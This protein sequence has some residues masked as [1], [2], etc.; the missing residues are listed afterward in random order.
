MLRRRL[1]DQEVWARQ[2]AA[3]DNASSD[4]WA[5]TGLVLR[6]FDGLVAGYAARADAEA[7]AVMGDGSDAVPRLTRADLLMVSA[8]GASHRTLILTLT[9]E[10]TSA[11]MWSCSA[12][13]C[14]Q[15][16]ICGRQNPLTLCFGGQ[17]RRWCRSRT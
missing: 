2:K 16:S 8:V 11:G 13:W 3:A 15:A 6:Q 1:V 5:A 10:L 4:F 12:P 9:L 17:Q 7:N 14:A